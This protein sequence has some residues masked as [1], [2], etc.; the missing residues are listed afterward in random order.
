M[1]TPEPDSPPAGEP[2]RVDSVAALDRGIDQIL[3]ALSTYSIIAITDRDGIIQHVNDRFCEISKYSREELVG[4]THRV[5]HSGRH[6]RE[7]FREMWRVIGGGQVWT[8]EICNRAKD[9]VEYWVDTTI[10][11]LC[12]EHGRPERYLAIRT[13]ATQRHLA[14]DE[15]RQLA[16]FDGSTGLAN[17][18]SMLR[19]VERTLA[20]QPLGE[21]C[22]YVSFSVD[23]LSAVNDAFGY[24][25]G[26]LLLRD[27]AAGLRGIE[28]EGLLAARMG[29]NTFGVL[30]TGLGDEQRLAES[31]CLDAVDQVL[32]TINGA[33]D[34]P[35]G[36][37]LDVSASLGFVLWARPGTRAA[38]GEP[39][40]PLGDCPLDDY[41]E[42]DDSAEIIKCADVA[43]KR[44]RR[45]GGQVRVR[46][47]RQRM[48]DE[49]QERVR[50]FSELR[51]GIEKGEL[52]L[53]AQP[54]VDRDRRVIG[55]EGLIR[56]V[57]PER[58]LVMPDAFIPL[59]EQTGLIIE[60]GDWVL[61]EACRV[62]TSWNGD[63]DRRGLTFSIN[64]SERQLRA[65]DFAERVHRI[66]ARH[67]ISPGLLKFELTESVLHTDLDRTIRM[68]GLLR[69]EGVL[70]S[71]DDFGTG[72][73]SLSYLRR[74]PVQQLKIDR[75]FVS[76]V[77]DDAHTA[78]I[79]QTIVQ[80]GRT[81]GLQVVAEGVET[82]AQFEALCELGVD[83]FQGY[84][85]ARPRPVS[86]TLTAL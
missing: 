1:H 33:S 52:R 49:A 78:A 80:L 34:L 59:A 17:R 12:D 8:G 66:L 21:F 74:L 70:A 36:M 11:P 81:F 47:F 72:Y 14:E 24:E 82:D 28:R 58:G 31:R 23:E 3:D 75:S 42:S 48:L 29:S 57:S 61:E 68:L 27:A 32:S 25:A 44:A 55:E 10:I 20:T 16:H 38:S 85:F 50:L 45:A 84:L 63:P 83:A 40:T 77:V 35:S 64:L 41:I 79:T 7:F 51:R 9:G 56:W 69:A 43:R 65:D 54:I 30:L 22:A 4:R 86:E 15:A 76:S 39:D 60:I 71:L 67:E 13:E 46:R 2:E 37:V 18:G 73:S 6:S 62:L 5:V 53:F 19:V 26:D